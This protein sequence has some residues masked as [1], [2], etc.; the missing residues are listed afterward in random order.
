MSKIIAIDSYQPQDKDKFFFDTNIWM[1]LYCPIG[2]YNQEIIR[3]YDGFLKRVLL[4]KSSI[5][6][7]SLVLSE[8]FNT[9]TRLEFNILKK[10]EP[11]K[12]QD[13]KRDFRR[14]ELYKK[15]VLQIKATVKTQILKLAK[16]LND[17]FSYI[18]LDE[19]FKDIERSDF[20]DNYYQLLAATENI[21]IVT[22]DYDFASTRKVPVPILTANYKLL[23]EV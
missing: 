2:N 15:L 13:F 12:Y 4:A 3:K 23:E 22:N 9:Y 6:I 7:S 18:N 10:K 19:L 5:F 20:N 21:K 8:F 14:T 1:Y 11:S 17:K 16:R